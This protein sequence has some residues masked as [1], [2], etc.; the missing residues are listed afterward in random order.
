MAK[1]DR[2]RSIPAMRF[3]IV[4]AL[5]SA[6]AGFVSVAQNRDGNLVKGD[7]QPNRQQFTYA[8]KP[9]PGSTPDAPIC[10]GDV[11]NAAMEARFGPG[12]SCVHAASGGHCDV[13][14]IAVMCCASCGAP[15]CTDAAA[16]A[17]EAR[18]GPGSSCA[19]AASGGHCGVGEIA[20]MCCASC[21]GKPLGVVGVR[22]VSPSARLLRI[23]SPT[24]GA[25][26]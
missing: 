17:M 9:I 19:H 3:V 7:F 14:D 1:T 10:Q 8:A 22:A 11:T 13:S 16:A 24:F 12:S 6:E 25:V 2:H 5:V 26:R 20:A 15:T 23:S 21:G 4:V 18:F